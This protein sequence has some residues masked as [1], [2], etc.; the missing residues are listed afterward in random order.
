MSLVSGGIRFMRIFAEVHH[1]GEASNDSG[2][3]ENI[4]GG[5]IEALRRVPPH[6]FGS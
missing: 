4:G 2:V 1:W 6:F 5:T 3:V